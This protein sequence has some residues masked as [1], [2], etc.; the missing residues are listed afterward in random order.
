[1]GK[2][3]GT[4]LPKPATAHTVINRHLQLLSKQAGQCDDDSQVQLSRTCFRGIPESKSR[5]IEL[6]IK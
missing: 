4:V 6:Q 5:A 3:M 2:E 1:M